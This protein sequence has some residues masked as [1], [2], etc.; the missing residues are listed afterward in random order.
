MYMILCVIDQ[1][2][3]LE[4]VL[5]AWQQLGLTG[6]TIVESTGLHRLRGTPHIAMRYAFDAGDAERGNLTLL[7]AVPHEDWI[8]RCL[9]ATEAI[10][11]DFRQ[12]NTGFFAAWPLS[13]VKGATPSQGGAP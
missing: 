3:H 9:A 5:Q 1:P 4:A 11:G 13:F 7:S 10:V 6:V 12:P 2:D 8:E